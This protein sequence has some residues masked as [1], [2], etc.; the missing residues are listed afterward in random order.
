VAGIDAFEMSI[1]LQLPEKTRSRGTGCHH[2]APTQQRM[3]GQMPYKVILV[4]RQQKLRVVIQQ[5]AQ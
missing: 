2:A 4:R 3:P 5:P 1:F